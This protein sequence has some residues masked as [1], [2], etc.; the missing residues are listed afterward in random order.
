M[1]SVAE[2]IA[3]VRASDPNLVVWQAADGSIK[4]LPRGSAGIPPGAGLDDAFSTFQGNEVAGGRPRPEDILPSALSATV[5][6][7]FS[8]DSVVGGAATA[9]TS[10]AP[11]TTGAAVNEIPLTHPVTDSTQPAAQGWHP[12]SGVVYHAPAST[13]GLPPKLGPME[14]APSG[15]E[16]V[17]N[18]GNRFDLGEMISYTKALF[19]STSLGQQ[20]GFGGS[21]DFTATSA[22]FDQV[23]RSREQ[24]DTFADQGTSPTPDP[25]TR[26]G[27]G[28]EPPPTGLGFAPGRTDV[29][30]AQRTPLAALSRETLPVGPIRDILGGPG[31]VSTTTN[32]FRNPTPSMFNALT[33]DEFAAAGTASRVELNTPIEDIAQETA[34]TFLPPDRRA[35]G[36]AAI[37]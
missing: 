5:P 24:R 11:T 34:R 21:Q 2:V 20:L 16:S 15:Q 33:G 8:G 10:G 37:I 7:G 30:P 14:S 1:P 13:G 32:P 36:R 4:A 31:F 9:P 35:R 28:N 18:Q 22:D 23:I 19:A 3:S 12:P 25:Q 17:D 6:P 29:N 27:F 26:I